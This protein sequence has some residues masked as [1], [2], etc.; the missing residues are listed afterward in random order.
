ML[1]LT[2]SSMEA[3]VCGRGYS[4]HGRW[5][6][7]RKGRSRGPSKTFKC[8]HAVTFCLAKLN[9]PIFPVPLQIESPAGQQIINTCAIDGGEYFLSKLYQHLDGYDVSR[10]SNLMDRFF[11]CTLKVSAHSEMWGDIFTHPQ[12][13]EFLLL[14][15]TQPIYF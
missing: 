1:G 2:Y 12:F 8:T 3:R 13:F 9:L 5:E 4:L 11:I 14:C 15:K 6:A 10:E 7:K